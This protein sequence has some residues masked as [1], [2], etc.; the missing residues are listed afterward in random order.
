MQISVK[1][2]KAIERRRVF[3]VDDNASFRAAIEFMLHDEYEAH[4]FAS[5][6]ATLAKAEQ[7]R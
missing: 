1:V 7:I 2:A 4:E 3:V 6:S 5:A